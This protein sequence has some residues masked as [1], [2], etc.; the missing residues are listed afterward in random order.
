ML[1]MQS[2]HGLLTPGQAADQLGVT[3][4][5]LLELARRERVRSNRTLGGHRRFPAD[6]IDKLRAELRERPP[7]NDAS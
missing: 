1:T 4:R 6:D 7:T 5:Q 2:P 3:R